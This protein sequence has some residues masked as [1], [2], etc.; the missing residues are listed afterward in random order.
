IGRRSVL[1]KPE[2]VRSKLPDPAK[3]PWPM[4]DLPPKDPLPPGLDMAKVEQ[5]VGAAFDPPSGLP[6]RSS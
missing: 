6:R 2:R 5:A 4:G 1:F 3:Q